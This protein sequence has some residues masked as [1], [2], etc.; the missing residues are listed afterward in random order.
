MSTR[1]PSPQPDKRPRLILR[2]VALGMLLGFVVCVVGSAVVA[3]SG[4]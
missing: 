1:L 4:S 3:W 2:Y